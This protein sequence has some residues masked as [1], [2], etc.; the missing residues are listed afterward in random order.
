MGKTKHKCIK[1]YF[2]TLVTST[3]GS[4]DIDV[5]WWVWRREV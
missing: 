3:I 5:V 2:D 4:S 1:A